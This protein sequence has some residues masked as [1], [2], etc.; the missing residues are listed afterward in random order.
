MKNKIVQFKIP[1]DSSSGFNYDI[2]SPLDNQLAIASSAN[3]RLD[4]FEPGFYLKFFDY[5]I[6]MYSM[7]VYE[8]MWSDRVPDEE[9]YLW[10]GT[11]F[12]Y[13]EPRDIAR[14]RIGNWK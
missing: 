7:F 4:S 10:S 1:F 11:S 8:V 5:D 2:F 14:F 9:M 12:K 13:A 3:K 6:N